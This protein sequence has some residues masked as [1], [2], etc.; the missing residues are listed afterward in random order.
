MHALID[1]RTSWI[2]FLNLTY[3]RIEI[4]W[5]ERMIGHPAQPK[6]TKI[7]KMK[8]FIIPTHQQEMLLEP[9]QLF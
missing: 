3:K 8:L 2:S 4:S 5:L 1:L 9:L 6:G 7:M